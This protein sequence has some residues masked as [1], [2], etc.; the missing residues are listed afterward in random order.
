MIQFLL[1]GLI[2]LGIGLSLAIPG[3][4]LEKWLVKKGF[5]RDQSG[6][7]L[8]GAVCLTFI[9]RVWFENLSW[10]IMLLIIILATT[11]GANRADLW[12]T[13]R[14]GRWWW[15]PENENKGC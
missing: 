13:F 2:T 9:K 5:V 10:W 1:F 8:F 14:R 4:L 6:I 12:T 15:K 3:L 7:I 11:L